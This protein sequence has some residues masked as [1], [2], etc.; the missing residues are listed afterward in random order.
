MPKRMLSRLKTLSRKTQVLVAIVLL[1]GLGATMLLLVQGNGHPH[2]ASA[3]QAAKTQ[4]TAAVL[5]ANTEISGSETPAAGVTEPSAAG[6][7]VSSGPTHQQTSSPQT[8]DTKT[9]PDPSSP[10]TPAPTPPSNPCD[11][12][13]VGPVVT[14]AETGISFTESVTVPVGCSVGPFTVKTADGHTVTFYGFTNKPT[15][16]VKA[17]MAFAGTSTG[18]SASYTVVVTDTATP[19]YYEDFAMIDDPASPYG[20]YVVTI[21]IT[22]IPR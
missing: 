19:G 20:G 22:V 4:K 8:A 10:S 3:K 14:Q 6:G 11:K 18:S 17:V 5:G 21:K 9:T 1:L 12:A 16:P 7:H 13:T 15:S 2:T